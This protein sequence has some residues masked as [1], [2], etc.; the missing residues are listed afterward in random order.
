V[1]HENFFTS[2]SDNLLR[3]APTRSAGGKS[4]QR[5]IPN[6][7]TLTDHAPGEIDSDPATRTADLRGY[8]IGSGPA[9]AGDHHMIT[10]SSEA[11]CDNP[12]EATGSSDDH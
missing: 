11:L 9:S 8:L 10:A 7:P 4:S 6:R 2:G 1:R 3:G 12:S 5:D